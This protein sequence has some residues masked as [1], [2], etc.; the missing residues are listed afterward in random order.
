MSAKRPVA[1][2]RLLRRN[3]SSAPRRVKSLYVI[4]VL[5]LVVGLD[6]CM[7]VLLNMSYQKEGERN[8]SSLGLLP[9]DK[10][11]RATST[12]V[13]ASESDNH[14]HHE[15]PRWIQEYFQW[16]SEMRAKYPGESL[17]TDPS[18]P[19]I[20]LR[21]CLGLCGGLNDRLGQLPWDLYLANQTKRIYLIRWERPKPLE[22][23]LVPNMI[24]WTYP[25]IIDDSK[26]KKAGMNKIRSYS[27]LFDPDT[28]DRPEQ[29]F[30]DKLL[31]AGIER[32]R[33]GALKNEKVLRHRLLGHLNEDLLEERLRQLG[34]TDMLH[35]TPSFGKIFYA[36]FQPSDGVKEQLDAVYSELNIAPREYSAV[37]CRVRHPKATAANVH[38][39]G[40][41]E[42]YPADKT[43]LPWTGETKDFAV[44]IATHALQCART[45]T[46]TPD[47]PIYFFSDSNDLAQYVA[48]D[49]K[50]PAFLQGN[51][52][53]FQNKHDAAAMQVVANANIVS[54]EQSMENAHIDRQKGRDPPAYFATFVDLFL[55]I[56]ARCVTYGIGFYAIFATKIS[57]IQCKLLYQEE[58]WGKNGEKSAPLC[59]EDMYKHLV[60]T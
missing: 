42:N 50:N 44:A 60:G 52:T 53:L 29:G 57:G 17:L 35:H 24:N 45:L 15:L 6:L 43:G 10:G 26:D 11:H 2:A 34:E 23:F 55:A 8:G 33:S 47:E 58:Q 14:H 25:L 27:T 37:H 36:F 30:W 3:Q 9:S 22:N 41:N 21:S 1:S 28:E 51:A 16:H 48:H 38:V 54:R 18:A 31:E 46:K 32:A 39:K 56:N 5:F 12:T 13:A 40:K 20:L 4:A 7:K 59:T 19:N 49:L